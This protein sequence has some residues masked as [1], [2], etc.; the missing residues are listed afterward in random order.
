MLDK[1]NVEVR[2][3]ILLYFSVLMQDAI[4]LSLGTTRKAHMAV[5]HEMERGRSLGIIWI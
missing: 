5:L 1:V 2:N 3:Q 4:E